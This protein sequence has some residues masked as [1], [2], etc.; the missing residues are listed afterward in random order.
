MVNLRN[1]PLQGVN[2][3]YGE[4]VVFFK[5]MV[6]VLNSGPL[7]PECAFWQSNTPRLIEG[8]YFLGCTNIN[9]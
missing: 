6:E 2:Q 4:L 3:N 1:E 9:L 5:D 8:W 7:T